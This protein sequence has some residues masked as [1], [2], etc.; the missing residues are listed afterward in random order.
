MWHSHYI[1][2]EETP[3]H[4]F[5]QFHLWFRFWLLC[6]LLGFWWKE[7]RTVRTVTESSLWHQYNKNCSMSNIKQWTRRNLS[8]P[9][10]PIDQDGALAPPFSSVIL[11]GSKPIHSRTR[12]PYLLRPWRWRQHVSS[13]Q[14]QYPQTAQRSKEKSTSSINKRE[15]LNSIIKK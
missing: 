12:T 5:Y 2:P 8:L 1:W 4:Y 3:L 15:R 14:H 7:S 13:K 10:V 11:L 6:F 9:T